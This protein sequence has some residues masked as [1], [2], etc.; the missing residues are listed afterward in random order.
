M[1]YNRKKIRIFYADD[2][3]DDCYFFEKAIIEAGWDAD[4][5]IFNNGMKLVEELTIDPSFC[6][7]IFMDI[8]MPR[9]NGI[10]CLADIRRNTDWSAVPV[11]MISTSSS[12]TL[13]EKAINAGAQGYIQK[14]P[15]FTDLKEQLQQVIGAILSGTE[16]TS[17]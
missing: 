11:F 3:A 1:S 15:N 8:N 7:I 9:R 14:P 6:N 16:N 12:Q 10:D 2:D 4:I 5:S 13:K 17:F